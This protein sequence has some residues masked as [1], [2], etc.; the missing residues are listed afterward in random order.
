MTTATRN[1]HELEDAIR[2]AHE[3]GDKAELA[4]LQEEYRSGGYPIIRTLGPGSVRLRD[5]GQRSLPPEAPARSVPTTPKVAG[6]AGVTVVIT[7]APTKTSSSPTRS[8][9]DSRLPAVASASRRTANSW[10]S[11]AP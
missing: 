11:A 1:V 10:L 9:T 2:R 5:S 4:R 6:G 7:R 3:A 8:A